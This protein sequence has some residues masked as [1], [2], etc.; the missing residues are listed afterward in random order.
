M[1]Q[2][3]VYISIDVKPFCRFSNIDEM[4]E[5]GNDVVS[6]RASALFVFQ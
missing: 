3:T 1:L 5:I 4:Y 6:K 2:G